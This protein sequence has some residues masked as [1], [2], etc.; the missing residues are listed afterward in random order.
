MLIAK[1]AI[2]AARAAP[3]LA[4]FAPIADGGLAV[5]LENLR[6]HRHFQH[7]V[8]GIGA[9]A[10]T[11]HAVAA[12]SGLEMLL[13][14]IVDEGVQIFHRLDPNV[15]AMPAI[16]AIRAAAFNE[17]FAPEADGARTPVARADVDFALVEKF[18]G[19]I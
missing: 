16:A 4:V 14:A 3:A 15:A 8:I 17:F 11:A 6:S 19:S 12:G 7:D 9:M 1:A 13:V 5:F 18:H 10:G 2:A